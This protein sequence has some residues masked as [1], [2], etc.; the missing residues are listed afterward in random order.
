MSVD[1]ARDFLNEEYQHQAARLYQEINTSMTY[2]V[3][4][5]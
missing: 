2:I 3:H 1:A 5:S 4:I